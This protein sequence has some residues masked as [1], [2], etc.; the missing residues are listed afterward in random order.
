[1]RKK[2]V[3]SSWKMH[4][5]SIKDGIK[6]AEQIK[7]N[8]GNVE[9]VEIFI[10]PTF[11]MIKFIADVFKGSNIGWGAQNMCFEEKGAYTG[12]VPANILKEL[13]CA[14]VEIGHAERRVLFNETDEIVNKKVKLCYKYD[15]VPIVCIGETQKDLDNKLQNIKLKTQ[16]LWALNGLEKEEMKKIIFAYE[17]VWAIGQ[18]EAANPKYVQSVHEFIRNV[19]KEEYGSEVSENVRIIY[20][21]SVSPESAKVLTKYNDID[22]LFIGR[23]GLKAENFKS[24]IE[25]TLNSY[26]E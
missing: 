13:E 10:L 20:G 2:I 19:I 25:T 22:G 15:L 9:D 6:L 26:K 17:P 12:E 7:E 18:S 21:G 16:V 3:G 14:Y 4:I 23:F 5:N 1:M 24:M 8:L 11:P